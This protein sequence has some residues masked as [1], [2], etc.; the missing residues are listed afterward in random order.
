MSKAA[1]PS[2]STSARQATSKHPGPKSEADLARDLQRE[3]ERAAAKEAQRQHW[4]R[5]RGAGSSVLA[6]YDEEFR[7]KPIDTWQAEDV[8]PTLEQVH[9]KKYDPVEVPS[10]DMLL[11]RGISEYTMLPKILGR[12]KFSTVFLAAKNGEQFAIKHTA[13]FPH[14][15]LISTRLLREPTLLAELPPHPNLVTVNETIRTP[16]H[17][18]LVEEYLG[19]YVT[20]EALVS[21]LSKQ[22]PD[23][24]AKLPDDAAEKVFQQ[25]ISVVNSIH[26]PLQICHRDIKPENILVH[27]VTLQLKLLDFGLATHFSRSEPKLSTC[28]GSPA[29][30]CPEIVKAL[31]SP[32]GS[33]MYWG[34]EVDAW[35]CG[36]TMLRCLTGVLY[37]LGAQHTSLRSMHIRAQRSVAMVSNP[38]LREKVAKLVDM[39]SVKR[40]RYFQEMNAEQERLLGEPQRDRKEFKSTTFIP[41]EASHTMRLPLLVGAAAEQAENLASG[42]RSPLTSS[43]NT[44][45]TSRAPSPSPLRH[46]HSSNGAPPQQQ[47]A[48]PGTKT[49]ILM[50]PTGQP[51]QRVLSFIKYC[52]RCAGILYHCWPDASSTAAA[53]AISASMLPLSAANG[54]VPEL[55]F[56][57]S[58]SISNNATWATLSSERLDIPSSGGSASSHHIHIFQCVLHLPEPIEEPEQQL[59]LVQTI[60]AA[61]GR[62]TAPNNKRS[63]SQP[64]KPNLADTAAAVAAAAAEG[65][66]KAA[67]NAAANGGKVMVRCL[68]FWM[69]I[70]L[71]KANYSSSPTTVGGGAAVRPGYHRSSSTVGRRSRATSAGG[72]GGGQSHDSGAGA[73][74]SEHS[75]ESREQGLAHV[76]PARTSMEPAQADAANSKEGQTLKVSDSEGAGGGGGN[77]PSGERTRTGSHSRAHS[78]QRLKS[79]VSHINSNSSSSKPKIFLYVSDDR[80]LGALKKALSVGGTFE[81]S[82]AEDEGGAATSPGA[83][84]AEGKEKEK[85]KEKHSNDESPRTPTSPTFERKSRPSVLRSQTFA[86]A[87]ALNGVTGTGATIGLPFPSV[88]ENGGDVPEVQRGRLAAPAAPRRS[89]SHRA[90][91]T[92]SQA[93]VRPGT[94]RGSSLTSEELERKLDAVQSALRPVLTRSG[95]GRNERENGLATVEQARLNLAGLLQTLQ[96][97][98]RAQGPVL[99]AALS[100]I[101]FQLFSVLTPVLGLEPVRA[102]ANHQHPL[103]ESPTGS[104]P[105]E[106]TGTTSSLLA[107]PVVPRESGQVSPNESGSEKE[108]SSKG[109]TKSS[110][111]GNSTNSA[112]LA[113]PFSSSSS[114]DSLDEPT[115]MSKMAR[116]AL[117][118]AAQYS[119]AR[120]MFLA[121]QERLDLLISQAAENQH[122]PTSDRDDVPDTPAT[123]TMERRKSGHQARR[124]AT[125]GWDGGLE[126]DGLLGLLCIVIPR[127]KTRKPHNFSESLASLVPRAT[128]ALLS[129]IRPKKLD[130]SQSK[131]LPEGPT[132]ENALQVLKSLVELTKVTN[133]WEIRCLADDGKTD[134]IMT[135][136]AAT[137][138]EPLKR[139]AD[140]GVMFFATLASLVPHLPN[141][142]QASAGTVSGLSETFF[143]SKNPKY[144]LQRPNSAAPS[145][146]SSPSMEPSFSNDET[147]AMWKEVASAVEG[148]HASVYEIA[149]GP[150]GARS[151][152]VVA[153]E[154]AESGH[155]QAALASIGAFLCLAHMM[156]LKTTCSNLGVGQPST[157]TAVQAHEHLNT[158]L[159]V[160]LAGL[161]CH[162]TMKI[163]AGGTAATAVEQHA[164]IE[165]LEDA[166]LVWILWCFDVLESAPLTDRVVLPEMAIALVQSLSMNTALSA[167]AARLISFLLVKQVIT[168]H[169]SEQTAADL[170][171]DIVSPECPFANLRCAGVGMIRDIIDLKLEKRIAQTSVAALLAPDEGGVLTPVFLQ[172]LRSVLFTLP[173]G[174]ERIQ[175]ASDKPAQVVRMQAFLNDHGAWLSECCHTLYYLLKRDQDNLTGIREPALQSEL[176]RTFVDPLRTLVSHWQSTAQK[177]TEGEGDAEQRQHLDSIAVSLTVISMGLG[178]VEGVLHTAD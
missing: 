99:Q 48:P 119:S 40:M 101:T 178:L 50:N 44:P 105:S 170:L 122:Q 46:A 176:R 85:E 175:E 10:A 70:R 58:P 72:S 94:N 27:P 130:P 59:S 143:F 62:R 66:E 41:T 52:L 4:E 31:A 106:S 75:P 129:Q 110:T 108:L 5:T 24:P 121:V 123:V 53:P 132:V 33:V 148:M 120:E 51:P 87:S 57:P 165:P 39:D 104:K 97:A 9:T 102:R 93:S 134:S 34:P 103:K 159:P 79:R 69:V 140:T 177:A 38:S 167:S 12:G 74:L 95:R 174:F 172:R 136:S 171:F 114:L 138:T 152:S 153:S 55:S 133:A 23:Q 32:P 116:S 151:I 11:T 8:L 76:A 2:A 146:P 126:L 21:L 14:H 1:G 78:R 98:E 92:Q 144:A 7:T 111:N 160:V 13:L 3:R 17:F 147:A 15:P 77:R 65:S 49:L 118:L 156:A 107:S 113:K 60:M 91:R 82:D 19:G 35:T 139:S 81:G 16:G 137:R 142:R 73:R 149:F 90:V 127:I 61:F 124:P 128:K 18:Y 154:S 83:A 163:G 162:A 71:S 169:V 54:A 63:L 109:S 45:N 173:S 36:I 43:R 166:A 145:A 37:P 47:P 112:P 30:H 164:P 20:L 96:D 89:E 6:L 28:C 86:S 168:H 157:W 56:P 131:G 88:D 42:Q 25:L 67:A 141:L 150:H 115:P 26:T 64:P 29:F 117:E 158:A 68:P 135:S 80:A 125:K 22:P 84:G 100:P 155:S 161:K